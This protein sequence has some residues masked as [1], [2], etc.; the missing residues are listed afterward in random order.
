MTNVLPILLIFLA[1]FAFWFTLGFLVALVLTPV[2]K[3]VALNVN[4]TAPVRPDRLHREVRPY[5]GGLAIAA[6]LVSFAAPLLFMYS[7]AEA[8]LFPFMLLSLAAV[9]FFIIGL[10][11]DRYA[12]RA[13]PKLGLQFLAAAIAVVGYGIKATVWLDVPF[14]GEVVSILWVVS[15]VNA[16]N[17]LDHADGLAAAVGIVAL[18]SLGLGQIAWF[19]VDGL[20]VP[21][22]AFIVAGALA[23]FLVHNFPP[24]KLFMGDAGTMLVGF[25]LAA[26][27]IQ[28]RYYHDGQTPSRLVVLVPL[29]ILAVPLFDMVCVT[30]SR[31]RRGESPF[32]GDATS[33]LAHRMLA[34]GWSPRGIVA[35]A[36]GASAVTGGASVAMYF[37]SGPA[38]MLPWL[39]VAAAL[40]AMLAV[41]RPPRAQ[42]TRES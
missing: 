24:A 39:A 12:F 18:T 19:M 41:R 26:L 23:G 22:P 21:W 9:L 29:A 33:H 25:L 16:Y 17:M 11:D 20:A 15:V 1:F 4:L 5:G 40:A 37:L 2:A 6:T 13:A 7:G 36:A 38:L 3:K 32:R 34:R 42:V 27:T 10:L 8:H 28:G 31:I 30:L 14:A 35:F